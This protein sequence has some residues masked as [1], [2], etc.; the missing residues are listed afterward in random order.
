MLTQIYQEVWIALCHC[1]G[2]RFV[3]DRNRVLREST[4]LEFLRKLIQFSN[5][6]WGIQYFCYQ[7][8]DSDGVPRMCGKLEREVIILMTVLCVYIG[9]FFKQY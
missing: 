9:E 1:Q 7:L 4:L 3:S 8:S 5:T 6:D 2:G